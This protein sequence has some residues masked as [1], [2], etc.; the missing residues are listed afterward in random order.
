MSRQ[1]SVPSTEL[2]QGNLSAYLMVKQGKGL[3]KNSIELYSCRLRQ[4]EV[5]REKLGKDYAQLDQADLSAFLVSLQEQ[6]LSASSRLTSVTAVKAYMRW[7]LTGAAKNGQL[8]GPLPE[9][10]AYLEVKQD[11]KKK[12]DVLVTP[13]LMNQILALQPTQNRKVFFAM[14]YDT[15]ARR[16]ELVNLRL[17]DLGRDEYGQFV[18][19]TGKTGYRKNWL[20]DS[21]SLLQG[22]RN[23]VG[24]DPDSWLFPRQNDPSKPMNPR[25]V[26]RWMRATVRK[27][28][29]R[30]VL[31]E[32]DR[33]RSHSFRHTKSRDLKARGW[34]GDEQNLW[35]GWSKNSNMSMH[36]GQARA[37]D[38]AG[39]FLQDTGQ[40]PKDEQPEQQ[41]C[42]ACQTVGGRIDTF[43]RVCGNALRPEFAAERKG[44]ENSIEYQAELHAA[45]DLLRK[46]REN[47][48]LAD[49]LGL[50][51]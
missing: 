34:S 14:M 15:G 35:M 11:Q 40:K 18:E 19:L 38:V 49:Q 1:Q 41:V 36:Y 28:K 22:Y 33:L 42:P 44:Q 37:E 46:L 3:K 25:G 13:E 6:G 2:A 8:K 12:P 24:T 48:I 5:W 31:K 39:R 21:L 32:T 23:S 10:V 4:F 20:S 26:D 50:S 27:L 47:P 16:G 7:L 30:G 9:A 29:A 45:R 43:C 17:R 51:D